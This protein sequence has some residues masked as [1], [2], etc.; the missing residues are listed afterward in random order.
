MKKQYIGV[1]VVT[2]VPMNSTEAKKLN[3]RVPGENI[4]GYEV[5]YKDGY[6]SWSPQTVFDEAYREI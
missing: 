4:E 2:A 6:K 3:Y 1:K 5:T